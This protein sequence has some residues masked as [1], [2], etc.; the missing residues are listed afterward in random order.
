LERERVE[1]GR[2]CM[3]SGNIINGDGHSAEALLA[4][5]LPDELYESSLGGFFALEIPRYSSLH[6]NRWHGERKAHGS[7][8]EL[9]RSAFRWLQ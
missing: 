2:E 4:L 3:A 5:W 8:I 7:T 6:Y 9:S 1:G